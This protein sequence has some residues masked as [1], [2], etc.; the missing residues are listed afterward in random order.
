MNF[1]CV[2][3]R[4]QLIKKTSA[5]E[6]DGCQSAYKIEGGIPRFADDNYV[7]NFGFEWNI[8]TKTQID[9]HESSESQRH[10]EAR[11]DG[12]LDKFKNA[13]VLDVG[14]GVGRYAQIAAKIGAKIV[15]VD[16]SSSVD[17]AKINLAEND[18]EL[19]QADV[20]NLPFEDKSFDIIY[21]FG[22]LHHTPNP[23]LAFSKLLPLLKPGGIMCIT[24]YETGSMYH[25]SRYARKITKKLPNQ[26]L[27]FLCLVYVFLMYVPYKYLGLRYGL[28]GRLLPISLSNNL[29]EAIL[30]TFDCYS[31]MYQFTYKESEIYAW[32]EDEGL[33][34]IEFKSEPVTVLG[35]K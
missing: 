13:K 31:P 20:F 21:S 9:N 2:K 10:F 29:F 22:V 30:D 8:H 16:L 17:I 6:C 24:L 33:K 26:F 7:S 14:V 12:Y 5:Y 28:L 23:R 18:A 15:G 35:T 25:T 11:F 19:I 34:N 32:F 3:C 4:T 1:I 27:Y